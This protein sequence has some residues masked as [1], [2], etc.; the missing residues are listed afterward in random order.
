MMR[1]RNLLAFAVVVGLAAA[2][3]ASSCTLNTM[4]EGAPMVTH[5]SSLA[6]SGGSLPD[7]LPDTKEAE[8][9][10]DVFKDQKAEDGPGDVAIEDAP[11]SDACFPGTK[12]CGNACVKTEAPEYGC[13][14]GVCSACVIPNAT[15]TCT[16]ESCAIEA[17]V[18]LFADCN[19]KVLDG[20]ETPINTT[21]NCAACGASC[22]LQYA[23]DDCSDGVHCT[24]KQCETG[25]DDCNKVPTDGCEKYIYGD[26]DNCGTCGHVCTPPNVGDTMKCTDGVCE[27]DLCKAG[28]ADCDKDNVCEVDKLTDVLNCGACGNVCTFANA[29][30]ECKAGVCGLKSCDTDWENCNGNE[31]DGCES[32]IKSSKDHC[33]SCNAPCST[34][35]GTSPSC[36]QGL[37][38]LACDDGFDN[39]NGPAPGNATGDDGC[40]INLQTDKLNCGSC[41]GACSA[42]HGSNV[43]CANG[44]C[45]LTCDTGYL[46]CDGNVPG[47]D[48]HNNGCE[49]HKTDDVLNCGVCGTV[50]SSAGGTPSCNNGVCSITC[51]AGYANCDNNV[52]NGCEINTTNDKSHCGNCSTICSSSAGTPACVSSVCTITCNSGSGNC[53]GNVTNGC[54]TNLISNSLHCG[55]CGAACSQSHGTTTCVGGSCSVQTCSPGYGNCDSDASNA[56]ELD[57]QTSVAHCGPC[58][59]G[60]NGGCPGGCTQPNATPQC[61]SGNCVIGSCN[62]GYLD[63]SSAA[64]GCETN[65][66]TDPNH[67]GLCTKI[68]D[69]TNGTAGCS[70]GSCTIACNSLYGNC[71]GNVGN[72][73]EKS[74]AAD[75]TNCGVCGK[76]CGSANGTPACNN[77]VCAIA[78]NSGYGD[79]NGTNSDGCETPLNTTNNCGQCGTKCQGANANWTCAGVCAVASCQSG[80][81]NCDGSDANG[82][83]ANF[84]TDNGHCGNCATSC[85]SPATCKSGV[86]N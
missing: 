71:D 21:T 29:V 50:C 67:C 30:G 41:G 42:V 5:D 33:G 86:C 60:C 53:D 13:A 25:H 76:T 57:T 54:E 66:Q 82:C 26:T 35:H 10:P 64:A 36:D 43:I 11:I 23:V 55:A 6:G 73:C 15:A 34:N 68:C 78:C 1:D 85:S 63:C 20:C 40:E 44:T 48:S 37:C 12:W 51:A 77:G 79:C 45:S 62:T 49:V 16:N 3:S 47:A 69:K 9:A 17:C 38:S 74:L 27:I 31:V 19:G 32:N 46:N 72:G 18:G 65:G 61:T 56:C 24:I 80:Y 7:A 28:T 59:A 58:L 8:A 39:C 83:E 75:T 2:A 4:G 81:G 52:T 22:D 84:N 70:L 14:P